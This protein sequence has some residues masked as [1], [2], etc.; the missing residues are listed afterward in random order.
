MRADA[1][2]D[3]CPAAAV[4]LGLDGRLQA[5]NPA[6]LAVTGWLPGELEGRNLAEVLHPKDMERLPDAA[7]LRAGQLTGARDVQVACR[8]GTW[9]RLHLEVAFDAGHSYLCVGR[10]LAMEEVRRQER[11]KMDFINMA[12]HE[13]NT[14]LTPIQLSIETLGVR[15]AQQDREV[16]RSVEMVQRNFER[17]RALVAELLDA[18]RVAAG[19]LPLELQEVDLGEIVREEGQSEI[20]VP[21]AAQGGVQVEVEAEEGLKAHADGARLRQVVDNFLTCAVSAAPPGGSVRLRA[22]RSGESAVV[23]V[24]ATG[25]DLTRRQRERLFH[26][27]PPYEEGTATPRCATGLGLF[28]ARAVVEL[29]GGVVEVSGQESAPGFSIRFTLPLAGPPAQSIPAAPGG[30][31]LP[32]RIRT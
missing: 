31:G 20:E 12:A 2:F 25:A 30:G 1:F 16:R 11:F 24:E 9:V 15:L 7:A 17:L 18:A 22:M 19:R 29:H 13:L 14:P 21:E 5:A 4:V 28:M 23:E 26:P 32:A 6:W 27:F 8:D 3:L 10:Q